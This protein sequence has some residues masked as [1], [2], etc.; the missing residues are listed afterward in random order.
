MA[1]RVK[2]PSRQIV[3]RRLIV[4]RS[5]S[6]HFLKPPITTMP[7]KDG[8]LSGLVA[9][10]VAKWYPHLLRDHEAIANVTQTLFTFPEYHEDLDKDDKYRLANRAAYQVGKESGWR[11]SWQTKKWF[12]PETALT[13]KRGKGTVPFVEVAQAREEKDSLY[14]TLVQRLRDAATCNEALAVLESEGI[15]GAHVERHV[16]QMFRDR[17]KAERQITLTKPE[18]SPVI[19][20]SRH[21]FIADNWER[22]TKQIAGELGISVPAVHMAAKAMGL[23][24]KTRFWRTRKLTEGGS[25]DPRDVLTLRSRQQT[26]AAASA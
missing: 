12:R 24:S 8:R 22:P 7:S 23:P 14:G 10:S 26:W 18:S 1:S 5:K 2:L 25:T 9:T 15:S 4:P 19:S 16:K 17:A 11:K 13:V 6:P 20:N 21:Q 3:L